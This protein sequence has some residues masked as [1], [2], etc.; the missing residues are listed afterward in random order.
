M[1]LDL[2]R[3]GYETETNSSQDQIIQE[4]KQLVDSNSE[5]VN[6][7]NL[8][9]I[10]NYD[11]N[12]FICKVAKL[13]NI[14]IPHEKF[15]KFWEKF[16]AEGIRLSNFNSGLFVVAYFF[17]NY[18][19]LPIGSSTTYENVYPVLFYR[20]EKSV[21]EYPFE[22]IQ[23]SIIEVLTSVAPYAPMR[24]FLSPGLLDSILSIYMNRELTFE[25]SVTFL[26]RFFHRDDIV[27]V[28]E[29]IIMNFIIILANF[30]PPQP[31]LWHFLCFF[32]GKYSEIIAPMCDFDSMEE[33]GLMP[34]FTRSLIWVIRLVVQHPPENAH[35]PDFWEFCFRVVKKYFEVE[36]DD[37]FRRLYFHIWNELRLAICFGITSAI[38]DSKIEKKV[39]QTLEYLVKIDAEGV[40]DT[41]PMLFNR[42]DTN[43]LSV[44]VLINDAS[45]KD[46]FT[47]YAKENAIEFHQLTIVDNIEPI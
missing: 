16:I 37:P 15:T 1:T 41:L 8:E 31:S 44:G 21:T 43:L 20:I 3:K 22:E 40:F 6:E 4:L 14:K 19:G 7:I 30:S 5:S 33:N 26:N 32:L 34:I 42:M 11:I 24:Y 39:V 38:V 35:Q 28:L 13:L 29:D 9:T 45:L 10:S 2:F 36:Q 23:L 47:Q 27:N 46:R 25:I 18:Q 17:E 12:D